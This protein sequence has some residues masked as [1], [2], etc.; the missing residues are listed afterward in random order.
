MIGDRRRRVEVDR[1]GVRAERLD[2]LVVHDL[3]D[4]LARRDRLD[5]RDADRVLPHLLD[6]GAHD[7]ERD[8]G[9]EQRAAHL[10][11]RR[12]DVGLGQR[13]APRQAIENSAKPFRQIVE[14]SVSDRFLIGIPKHFRAR[15]RIALSGGGRRLRD[16]VG[17]LA[18]RLFS[19]APD[20]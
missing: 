17:E 4:H 7:V 20:E 1:I 5:H 18:L 3:D 12:V 15:G 13:A 8:V 2:Q 19:R 9:F 6:E 11:Q 16:P 14:H 10:A